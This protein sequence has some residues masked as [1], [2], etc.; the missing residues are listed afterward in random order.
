MGSVYRRRRKDKR[1]RVKESPIWWCK[2]SR[3]DGKFYRESSG[4]TKRSDAEKLLKL[5]EGQ[6]G[7]GLLVTS[8]TDRLT[9]S[10]LARDVINDY[11]IQGRRT[12]KDVKRRFERHILPFFGWSRLAVTITT[13][14]VREF[15]AKRLKA[16][17][18][19]GEI[20]R[21]L[22]GLARGFSLA[23]QAALITIRPHIQKLRE[24]NTRRGFFEPEQF[25]SVMRH[26]P[27]PYQSVVALAYETGWRVRSELLPLQWRQVDWRGERIVLDP[28]TTKNE[29][30]RNFPF[31][32]GIR[33]VLEDRRKA[34]ER[35]KREK[36]IICAWVFWRGNGERVMSFY[37]AWRTAC[38]KA[39][40][41]GM[42]LHDLRRTAVR[43]LVR[44]GI[45]E[46]IAMQL[47]GHRTRLVFDRY[48]V[49]C[50]RDLEIAAQRLDSYRVAMGDNS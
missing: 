29:Q 38:R 48:H 12:T 35:L 30:G 37:K 31:T 45:P 18:S 1:G 4:S 8:R 36:G 50:E 6:V 25:E 2:W 14:D 27:L 49:I 44:A 9:L 3:G 19:R 34:V 42:I 5:R 10:Q 32:E 33:S 7:R 20:N 26:L 47:T 39:G 16:S 28:N 13:A 43:N 24:N 11:E 15:V 21:E 46:R 22:S 41:P 17:A 23:R 40:C